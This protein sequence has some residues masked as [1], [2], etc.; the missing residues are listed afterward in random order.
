MAPNLINSL[1]MSGSYWLTLSSLWKKLALQS[2]KFVDTN[3]EMDEPILL[4]I[5]LWGLPITMGMP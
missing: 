4:W 1:Q 5:L 2:R 3:E